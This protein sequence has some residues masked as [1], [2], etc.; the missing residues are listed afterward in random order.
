MKTLSLGLGLLLTSLVS[1]PAR[2][3]DPALFEIRFETLPLTRDPHVLDDVLVP[4]FTSPATGY[5]YAPFFPTEKAFFAFY[6]GRYDEAA[7]LV[8][9]IMHNQRDDR[10]EDTLAYIIRGNLQRRHGRYA[11]ALTDYL[12]ALTLDSKHYT[13]YRELAW[14]LSTS[15]NDEIRDA[16]EAL[17]LATRACELTRWKSSFELEAFAAACA[18]N[19]DFESAVKWQTEAIRLMG[20]EDWG[21]QK[22]DAVGRLELFLAE[23]PFR[24]TTLPRNEAPE[25]SPPNLE[26]RRFGR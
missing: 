22:S 1:F 7:S 8:T 18:E 3:I 12:H 24:E 26:R 6:D 15:S 4:T 13:A 14:L 16:E 21:H 19:G 9:S 11:R 10:P 20:G 2:G 17:R 5:G 23:Q 25:W